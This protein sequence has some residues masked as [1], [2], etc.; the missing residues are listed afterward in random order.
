[1]KANFFALNWNDFL[2]GAIVAVLTAVLATL[3]TLL[4]TGVLFDKGSLPVIGT[5]ALT[6]FIAYLAK[7]LLTNSQGQFAVTE[8]N[9]TPEVT[10]PVQ[11]SALKTLILIFLLGG[12]GLVCSAQGT[13]TPFF[14]PVPKDLFKTVKI[15]TNAAIT[16]TSVWLFRPSAEITAI[17]LVYNKTTKKFDSSPLS[18]AGPGLSYQHYVDSNGVPFNDFGFNAL[19]LIGTDITQISPATLAVA[20][21][22]NYNVF[23]VGAGYNCGLKTFFILTGITLKF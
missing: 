23:N 13:S 9:A 15:S 19:L 8:K 3:T 16:P 10:K 22:V 6:A 14:K 20:G 1:M 17:E 4:Q 18:S 21:T 2:K 5:A 12:A 11:G 7:N